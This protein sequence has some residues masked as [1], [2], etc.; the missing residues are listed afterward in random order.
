MLLF[1][2]GRV[3]KQVYWLATL[4]VAAGSAL[5]GLWIIIANSWQQTPAGYHIVNGR[6]E[7][8]KFWE[9]ALNPS[10]L[11]RYT[12]TIVAS[13]IAGAFFVAGI[14]AWYLLKKRHLEFAQRSLATALVIGAIFSVLGPFTGHHHAVPV[15]HTQPAKM[16]AFEGLF[17]SRKGAPMSI[18]GI[19]DASQDVTHLEVGIP[20]LVSLLI[21]FNPDSEVTGLRAF[22]KDEW[23]PLTLTFYSYHIMIAL[24]MYFILLT[25]VALFLYFTKRLFESRFMLNVLPYSLPLPLISIQFAW[26]A[27]EVGRQPWI[28]YRELRTKDAISVVVPAGQI[29][30]TILM[31]TAVY[32]LL[33]VLFV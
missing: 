10:T 22:P 32:A 31:F 29:L 28:V 6:A 18:F 17:E 16:A 8:T 19:P 21:D 5:S 26:I 3:S 7:L 24:G 4:M 30:F 20:K 11:P 27:A 12:H 23:P 33:F 14:S 2:R 25:L 13:L 9:A 1:A 15:A